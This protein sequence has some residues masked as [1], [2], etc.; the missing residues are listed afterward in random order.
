MYDQ[1]VGKKDGMVSVRVYMDTP[2][3]PYY[4]Q[5]ESTIKNISDDKAE[6]SNIVYQ[7]NSLVERIVTKDDMLSGSDNVFIRAQM[8]NQAKRKLIQRKQ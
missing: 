6:G 2:D 8:I 7:D 5:N 4:F 3:N 1:I